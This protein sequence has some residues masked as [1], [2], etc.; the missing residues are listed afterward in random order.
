MPIV[1]TVYKS[2]THVQVSHD[3]RPHYGTVLG[4]RGAQD[5]ESSQ[6]NLETDFTWMMER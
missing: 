6:Q 2:V 1:D 3:K 5:A 4:I